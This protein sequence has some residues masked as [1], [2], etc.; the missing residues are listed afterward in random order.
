MLKPKCNLVG[1]D[2]NIFN[3]MGI[4][5]NALKKAGLKEEA[6]EMK[7]K[8]MNSKSYDQAIRIIMEYVD[9]E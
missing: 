5:S 8:I 1:K 4:A 6:K 2:G 9:V 3:L 7:D